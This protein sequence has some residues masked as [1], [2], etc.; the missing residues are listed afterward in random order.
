[1]ERE[2]LA[3]LVGRNIQRFRKSAGMTQAQLAERINVS[4]AFVSRLERGEKGMSLSVLEA[5]ADVFQVSYDALMRSPDFWSGKET[6][7][8]LL[9]G[10]SR[11]YIAWVEGILRACGA[12]PG[13]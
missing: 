12:G 1:M 7:L 10:R 6:I 2:P 3:V 11:A 5:L 13:E 8:V 9:E 4:T